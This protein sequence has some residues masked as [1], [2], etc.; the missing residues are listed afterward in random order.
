MK[1]MPIPFTKPAVN[2]PTFP[3]IFIWIRVAYNKVETYEQFADFIH[4][5]MSIAEE[6]TNEVKRNAYQGIAN[7][8]YSREANKSYESKHLEILAN[9]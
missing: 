6:T 7:A 9:S 1:T 5:C 8:L 4:E 3:A 2:F